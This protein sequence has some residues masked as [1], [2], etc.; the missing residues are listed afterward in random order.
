M[1]IRDSQYGGQS[2]D[3]SHLG[4]YLRRS[5]EKFRKH[6]TYE[7]AGQVDDATIERL[8]A[9]RLK[10]ELK[11]GVQTIQ[12]LSLIHIFWCLSDAGQPVCPGLCRGGGLLP[13]P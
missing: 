12:Y 5:K 4:K 9:D 10:D 11:S 2:V 8:V 6:I 13:E 1:C 7:C 3:M